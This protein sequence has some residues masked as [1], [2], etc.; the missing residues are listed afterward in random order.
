VAS[1]KK[2]PLGPPP[3]E[4]ASRTSAV[5]PSTT[6]SNAAKRRGDREA[7]PQKG[8]A[9]G[10]NVASTLPSRPAKKSAFPGDN[11]PSGDFTPLGDA[12]HASQPIEPSCFRGDA[13]GGR[14]S[15]GASSLRGGGRGLSHTMPASARS[16]RGLGRRKQ[17]SKGRGN[18]W[19]KCWGAETDQR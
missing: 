10:S 12:A 7:L 4:L 18:V 14:S 8:L 13:V 11:G 1:P 2:A 3:K 19:N 9:K 16:S 5:A 6:P 17:S 15:D